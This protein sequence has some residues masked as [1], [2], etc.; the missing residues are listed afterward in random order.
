MA[1]ADSKAVIR[2]KKHGRESIMTYSCLIVDDEE[3]I[4][5]IT[6][7]YFNLFDINCCY[8][9]SYEA[10][11]EFLQ[12]HTVSLLLLDINLGDH[13]GFDLC[14]KLRQTLSI[15]I[16]F[17]SACSDDDNILTALNIGG[18]DYIS[19]P[20]KL[21]ILLAK[22]RAILRRTENNTPNI[23]PALGESPALVLDEAHRQVIA[24][25]VPVDLKEMEF[26]LL[27]YMM[28]HKGVVLTKNE[29]FDEVW[30][31]SFAGDGTLSVHIR[32]LRCKIEK[33]P[34]N[35][36]YIKTRWGVG[37]VFEVE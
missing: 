33:D 14:K 24:D 37:Y 1:S 15:P 20:F 8:V 23:H 32:H 2:K 16:L 30:K 34:D 36:R 5:Q 27:R 18:D 7:E 22:V 12:N 26:K 9:T 19:K 4:A 28:E 11:M 6:C 10:C 29:L 25:G 31:D 3:S 17:I 21:N 13:S 35:P